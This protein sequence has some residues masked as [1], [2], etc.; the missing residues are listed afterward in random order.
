MSDSIQNEIDKFQNQFKPLQ[1]IFNVNLEQFNLS[2]EQTRKILIEKPVITEIKD[3]VTYKTV[4]TDAG[5]ITNLFPSERP[6]DDDPY[7]RRHKEDVDKVLQ[8]KKEIIE[9]LIKMTGD[10]IKSSVIKFSPVDFVQGIGGIMQL[11]KGAGLKDT[12]DPAT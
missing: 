11:A 9:S 8:H 12:K 2:L 4:L 1:D 6:K 7:W 3:E 10:V 5:S